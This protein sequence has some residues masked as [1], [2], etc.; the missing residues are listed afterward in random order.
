M[1]SFRISK[2]FIF[3]GVIS[4]W[5]VWYIFHVHLL[6]SLNEIDI[7]IK[8]FV[9][10]LLISQAIHFICRAGALL[11]QQKLWKKFIHFYWLLAMYLLMKGREKH[12]W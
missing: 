4:Y 5:V 8:K 10:L 11:I 2:Q 1:Y 7:L 3:E 9:D 12:P 6:S